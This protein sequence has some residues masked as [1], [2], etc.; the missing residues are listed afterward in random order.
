LCAKRI[1]KNEEGHFLIPYEAELDCRNTIVVY[2]G[3]TTSLKENSKAFRQDQLNFFLKINSLF[4]GDA[5]NY[6]KLLVE[7]GSKNTVKVLKGGYELFSRMYP[8]LRT[9]QIIYM[10]HVRDI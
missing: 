4:V 5:V 7:S 3:H 2:D 8:F 1:K 9:Q 6:A 10:P